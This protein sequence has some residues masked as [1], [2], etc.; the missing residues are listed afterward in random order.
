MCMFLFHLSR[1]WNRGEPNNAG[2]HEEC[3]EIYVSS[4][5]WNDIKCSVAAALCQFRSECLMTEAFSIVLLQIFFLGQ[6]A[7]VLSFQP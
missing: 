6:S 4:G 7:E 1:N 3:T 2:H 5:K